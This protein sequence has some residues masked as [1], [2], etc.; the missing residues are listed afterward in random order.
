MITSR[1]MRRAVRRAVA[2]QARFVNRRPDRTVYPAKSQELPAVYTNGVWYRLHSYTGTEP[3]TGAPVT[4]IPKRHVKPGEFPWSR[5]N[6]TEHW[7]AL[8]DEQDR[9]L[10]IWAPGIVTFLGGFAGKEGTGGPVDGPTGYISP[11][12]DE[13]IDSDIVYEFGFTLIA[14]TLQEIR[15][16]VYERSPHR[17]PFDFHFARDREHWYPLGGLRD[18]GWPVRGHLSLTHDGGSRSL[19]ASPVGFWRTRDL[20][21]VY[22][23]CTQRT[24]AVDA[25]PGDTCEIDS[26][27]STSR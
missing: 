22:L 25:K 2:V 23:R 20:P 24:A 6:A 16:W 26:I 8:L 14:G 3:F 12:R 18:A 9:G 17:M 13:L 19:L 4:V 7:A 5:F 15:D 1:T 10:G 27:G 11:I 21:R